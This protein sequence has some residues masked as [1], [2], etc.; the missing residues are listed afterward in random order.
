MQRIKSFEHT[1]Y[2]INEANFDDIAL[3]LFRWQ[4]KHNPVYRQYLTHLGVVP[5]RVSAVTN[6]PFLPISFFKYHAV[7]TGEWIPETTFLSSGTTGDQISRHDVKDLQFYLDHAHRTFCEFYGD[8]SQ[9]HILALMPS[10]LERSGSSLI[11]MV[12][13]LIRKSNSTQ[14]GFWR[15][16]WDELIAHIRWLQQLND[17]KKLLLWGVSFALLDLSDRQEIDLNDSIVMETGGMKGRREELTREDL[18]RRL[19]D[20][21]GVQNIHSEYGMTELLSQAYSV[22]N[23]YFKA[24]AWMKV[25]VRDINDPFSAVE[26]GKTGTINVIDLGN[27]HTCSFIETQDLGRL[28]QDGSFEVLG[29]LDNSDRR[30]CNLLVE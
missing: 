14:S 1:L 7:R 24:S 15:D 30:G 23:G 16:Q 20:R 2:G 21:L 17:G 27:A 13:Y 10:Y 12:D 11:A 28:S 4:A 22:A 29:R 6:I 5:A 9:Y 25:V 18:H 3:E 26:R 19:S 8:P